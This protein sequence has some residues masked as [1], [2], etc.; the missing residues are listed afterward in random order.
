MRNWI[1][2]LAAV[3]VLV[4]VGTS[5][6]AIVVHDPTYTALVSGTNNNILPLAVDPARNL[7]YVT[8]TSTSSD[9][10]RLAPDGT[11]ATLNNNVGFVVGVFAD[12]EVGFGGDLFANVGFPGASVDGVIRLNR[13]TGAASLFWQSASDKAFADGGLAFDSTTQTLYTQSLVAGLEE[14]EHK[15]MAIMGLAYG[16]ALKKLPQL[17]GEK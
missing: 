2:A 16:E 8:S 14:G 3:G 1:V 17:K 5:R 11:E 7:Y 6:G 13:L 12:L 9:F 10:V 4:G 15:E